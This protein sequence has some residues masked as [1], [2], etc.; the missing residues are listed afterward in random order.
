MESFADDENDDGLQ[1]IGETGVGQ[2][3]AK[4][5]LDVG[6]YGGDDN[7]RQYSGTYFKILSYQKCKGNGK[8]GK[9]I[10]FLPQ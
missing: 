4:S 8:R 5:V 9:K 2:D 10:N 6:G 7:N 1:D 3:Q